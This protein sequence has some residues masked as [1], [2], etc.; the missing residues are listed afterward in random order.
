MGKFETTYGNMEVC[1]VCRYH[2]IVKDEAPMDLVCLLCTFFFFSESRRQ[3]QFLET[4]LVFP[5][6]NNF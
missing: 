6:N 4:Y 3:R 1:D 2:L 5:K